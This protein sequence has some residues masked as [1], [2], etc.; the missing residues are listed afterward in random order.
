MFRIETNTLF[1]YIQQ[2]ISS[3]YTENT[4][5][6]QTSILLVTNPFLINNINFQY[7]NNAVLFCIEYANV[8]LHVKIHINLQ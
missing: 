3:A 6:L 4:R 1:K 2:H 8:L 5:P 7:K